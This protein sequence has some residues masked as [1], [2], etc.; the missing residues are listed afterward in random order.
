[1]NAVYK[2]WLHAAATAL[3]TA[4]GPA[5]N[6]DT[7]LAEPVPAPQP[8]EAVVFV[9]GL[10]LDAAHMLAYRPAVR[11][12]AARM[13]PELAAR[14]PVAVRLRASPGGAEL[15]AR[16]RRRCAQLLRQGTRQSGVS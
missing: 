6:A 15:A 7:Y 5:A 13:P 10:R 4:I 1:M 11:G 8:G 14:P 12:P 2:P 9:D 3:Q 16:A